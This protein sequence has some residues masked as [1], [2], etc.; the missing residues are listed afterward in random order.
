MATITRDHGGTFVHSKGDD[1]LCV[2]ADASKAVQA[3]S[4]MLGS[5]PTGDVVLH[6]GLHWGS[7]LL[8]R[9]EVF[10]D[11]VNLTARLASLA[12]SGEVLISAEL[13]AELQT[14]LA[15]NEFCRSCLAQP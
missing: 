12:N 3:A 2:F 11:A 10:G 9:N 4:E 1:A 13:V 8:T 5:G 6:G 14:M 7:V 15:A